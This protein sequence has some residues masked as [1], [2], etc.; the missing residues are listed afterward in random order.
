MFVP[1]EKLKRSTIWSKC[2]SRSTNKSISKVLGLDIN[3]SFKT[4]IKPSIPKLVSID[5]PDS[6]VSIFSL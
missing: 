3:K 4:P 2:F 6:K 1:K 5:I